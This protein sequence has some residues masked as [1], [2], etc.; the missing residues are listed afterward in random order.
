MI[1]TYYELVQDVKKS[2]LADRL[3]EINGTT[4]ERIRDKEIVRLAFQVSFVSTWIGDEILNLFLKDE[5]FSVSI[6]FCWQKNSNYET[7]RRL[8]FSHF[9]KYKEKGC[10]VVEAGEGVDPSDYD[11]IIFTSPYL[12][13]LVGFGSR[14]IP[15]DTLVCHVPYGFLIADI[16]EAQF[17]QFIHI[18]CWRNYIISSFYFELGDK[19]CDLGRHGM[20]YSGYPKLDRLTSFFAGKEN[21]NDDEKKMGGRFIYAPHHSINEVPFFSTFAENGQFML[22]MARKRNDIF[23]TFKPHPLLGKSTIKNGIFDEAG[24]EEYANAWANLPHSEI[25]FGDYMDSFILSDGLI[26]DSVSFL[27][28]YCY[29]NKPMLFLAREGERFNEFGQEMMK[30]IYSVEGTNTKAIEEFV[31]DPYSKDTLRRARKAFFDKYLNYYKTNGML[32]GE[33]IYKD[34]VE[35]IYGKA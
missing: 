8:F 23:W 5:R 7:E 20:V 2:I 27:A 13:A 24:F 29:T 26:L 25:S 9:D 16:P 33:F 35:S 1:N 11:I 34:I 28:E 14:D 3:D 21:G 12:S 17:N 4:I 10:R 30:N 19:Y 18:I 31:D 6:V 22:D 15:L 32:A